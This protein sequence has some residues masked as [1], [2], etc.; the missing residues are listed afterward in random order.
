[1]RW[2]QTAPILALQRCMRGL[3]AAL[4]GPFKI[5]PIVLAR[6]RLLQMWIDTNDTI[7]DTTWYTTQMILLRPPVTQPCMLL[8]ADHFKH[9]A[10]GPDHTGTRLHVL[11]EGGC[12]AEELKAEAEGSSKSVLDQKNAGG[13]TVRTDARPPLPASP[14]SLPSRICILVL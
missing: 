6:R 2:L 12:T 8:Y 7:N 11:I 5:L 9:T 14:T 1:M 13:W 3:H 10:C 4:V